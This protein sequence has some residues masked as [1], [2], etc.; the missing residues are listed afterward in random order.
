MPD[1]E[2]FPSKK[3]QRLAGPRDKEREGVGVG[4]EVHDARQGRPPSTRRPDW[5]VVAGAALILALVSGVA[6]VLARG[7]EHLVA[8]VPA[9]ALAPLAIVAAKIAADRLAE[10]ARAAFLPLAT[11]GAGW[12]A[13]LV[14]ARSAWVATKERLLLQPN[15]TAGIA[16]AFLPAALLLG[17]VVA[18][19]ALSRWEARA[20]KDLA[21]RGGVA[22]TVV[23]VVVLVGA[24]VQKGNR[25]GLDQFIAGLDE[26]TIR[27]HG[28]VPLPALTT[29]GRPT[30]P[31]GAHRE[32]IGG[33]AIL[34]S[35]DGTGCRV[36]VARGTDEAV[37]PGRFVEARNLRDHEFF[38]ARVRSR[39]GVVLLPDCCSERIV[40]EERG[41][42]FVA[43]P[44]SAETLS[45]YVGVPLTSIGVSALGLIVIGALAWRRRHH[46]RRR[47]SIEAAEEG[48]LG[49]DGLISLASS[50]VARLEVP[51]S[52]ARGPVLLLR[53]EPSV[54]RHLMAPRQSAYREGVTSEPLHVVAG[55][56]ADLL[57][58]IDARLLRVDGM[59]CAVAALI[60][61]PLLGACLALLRE[62]LH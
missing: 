60:T 29:I 57:E 40:F 41:E 18:A 35:C 34:Q 39:E 12:V 53:D 54:R 22:A 1:S 37:A 44:F 7:W 4:G 10:K 55:H 26:N 58:A 48:T 23:A 36:G 51:S 33:V 6:G 50:R 42:G 3:A 2:A 52:V 24:L 38:R 62:S 5:V 32:A 8:W 16:E 11:A 30:E 14:L 49:K 28:Y 15:R 9:E 61:A 21:R 31:P 19:A 45:K 56:R 43:S 13:A 59:V 27:S 17:F 20:Q 47:R 25:V 46:L